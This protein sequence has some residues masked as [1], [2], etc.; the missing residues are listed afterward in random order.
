[1]KP[2]ITEC[3]IALERKIVSE[4]DFL[5]SCTFHVKDQPQ[6]FNFRLYTNTLSFQW[7]YGILRNINSH[8]VTSQ[9]QYSFTTVHDHLFEQFVQII[10][11]HSRYR[12]SLLGMIQRNH[13]TPYFKPKEYILP[14]K[15]TFDE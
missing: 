12:L 5:W 9:S 2:I 13:S 3:R 15:I 11:K 1:M 7:E 14:E 6:K 8:G 10:K 4:S